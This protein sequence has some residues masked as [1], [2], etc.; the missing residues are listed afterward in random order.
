VAQAVSALY[1][2]DESDP[3]YEV[4]YEYWQDAIPEARKTPHSDATTAEDYEALLDQKAAPKPYRV[5]YADVKARLNVIDYAYRFTDEIRHIGGKASLCCILPTH[6]EKT[7]SM[8][9]YPNSNSFYCFGC[10]EGGD[11]IDLIKKMGQ[12]PLEIP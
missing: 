8:W 6:H 1:A 5:T 10:R 9:L 3:L 4:V 11:L 7:P 12:D 2:L